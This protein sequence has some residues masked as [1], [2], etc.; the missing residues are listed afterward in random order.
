MVAYEFKEFPEVWVI[1]IT[2][3]DIF[4]AGLPIYH[5]ERVITELDQPFEDA[6]HIM[7]V[8]GEYRAEDAVGML[9]HDFF[10][11][12]P[13]QMHYKELAKRADFFKHE[14]KGVNSMCKIM[15][16]LRNESR[17][18]GLDE[19]RTTTALDMLRDNE[20]I[21][22]IIKY[23]HLPLERIEELAQQIH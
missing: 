10:C 17:T 1:F 14:P 11:D 13:D 8:N 15:Q 16:D 21:E 7:Y 19:A 6:A 23:S 5:V 2:E 12:D 22:K 9:M 20:P 18:E 3:N 4:N